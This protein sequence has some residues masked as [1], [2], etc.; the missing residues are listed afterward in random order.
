MP[1]PSLKAVQL[2]SQAL[3]NWKGTCDRL[4]G[5]SKPTLVTVGTDDI[6]IHP[7]YSLPLAEKVPGAWLVQ[8][9]GDKGI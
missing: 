2:E 6:I 5:I 3:G 1:V 8:V 7:T 9:K 4:S